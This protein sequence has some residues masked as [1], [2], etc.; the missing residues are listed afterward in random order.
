MG[1]RPGVK[2]KTPYK[3]TRKPNIKSIDLMEETYKTIGVFQRQ[4]V[5]RVIGIYNQ[6]QRKALLED[7]K[8][9]QLP[10]IG[11]LYPDGNTVAYRPTIKAEHLTPGGHSK[12][13]N[14]H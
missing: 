10:G 8:S 14:N 1:R 7:R 12:I 13:I 5:M 2:I 11:I 9:I 4:D 6:I 3:L